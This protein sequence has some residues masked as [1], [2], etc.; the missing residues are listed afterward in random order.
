MANSQTTISK[1]PVVTVRIEPNYDG[2][3][4]VWNIMASDGT[5][6]CGHAKCPAD[7]MR[8]A[9]AF[10]EA[11]MQPRVGGLRRK[12]ELKVIS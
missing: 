7:A 9:A 4:I 8:D 12:P 5:K 1:M 2:S 3:S 10:V 6:S 11:M